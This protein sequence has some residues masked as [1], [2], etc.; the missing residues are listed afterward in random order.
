M[1]VPI[2]NTE[3]Y[4]AQCVDSILNQTYRNLEV[5]LVDDGSTDNSPAICD[6]YAR[7]DGRVRVIHKGNS[8]AG[9]ARNAG[10]DVAKG[11]LIGTVDSDDY[12]RPDMYEK[13]YALM[14]E[15]D[16][17]ISVG[18]FERID[19]AGN[20]IPMTG[21]RMPPEVL[22][23]EQAIE[24]LLFCKSGHYIFMWNRLY[25]AKIFKDIRFPE[26]S[27]HDDT[28]TAHRI[29]WTSRKTAV[30]DTPFYMYRQTVTGVMGK[31]ASAKFSLR[32]IQDYKYISE[33]RYRFFQSIGRPEW[34][35][36][37]WKYYAWAVRTTLERINYMQYRRELSPYVYDALKRL[38]TSGVFS[39]KVRAVKF[40]L[41][42]MCS[43]FRPFIDKEKNT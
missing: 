2:Y 37:S 6:D 38:L 30:T 8:C 13:L 23:N 29:L 17:D 34:A 3:K 4:L 41:S 32:L 16:A 1:I 10:L 21:N 18:E 27:R 15:N 42:W 24:R 40:V 36:L 31:I 9:V 14:V 20:I 33:D 5:I 25:R 11:E 19:E 28:A 39:D 35:K 43:I 7:K 22:S 26:G 12:I